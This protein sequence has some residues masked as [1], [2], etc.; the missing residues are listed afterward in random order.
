M[1]SLDEHDAD[2]EDALPISE[3]QDVIALGRQLL[4]RQKTALGI[5]QRD[6]FQQE[7]LGIMYMEGRGP[8]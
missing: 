4:F 5:V 2:D 3:G 6:L 1:G 8:V 7:T